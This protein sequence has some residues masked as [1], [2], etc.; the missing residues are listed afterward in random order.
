MSMDVPASS[1]PPANAQ[2]AAGLAEN[3]IRLY[4]AGGG[5]VGQLFAA[6]AGLVVQRDAA[7][8]LDCLTALDRLVSGDVPNRPD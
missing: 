6:F 7:V 3:L 5:D 2:M 8:G 4:V 1:E